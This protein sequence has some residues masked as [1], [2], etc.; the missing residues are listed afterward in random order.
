M[1]I[2]FLEKVGQP[3]VLDFQTSVVVGDYRRE[4]PVVSGE[5]AEKS[6]DGIFEDMDIINKS[7]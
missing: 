5:L 6:I 7:M 3:T 1:H 2:D 4:Y